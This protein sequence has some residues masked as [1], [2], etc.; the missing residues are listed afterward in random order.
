MFHLV[1]KPAVPRVKG[2]RRGQSTGRMDIK[3]WSRIGASGAV[4][5]GGS[6]GLARWLGSVPTVELETRLTDFEAE[7]LAGSME[8]KASSEGVDIEG[9]FVEFQPAPRT[10]SGA[11]T[12]L[13]VCS[14]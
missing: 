10:D 3:L 11:W 1:N 12:R 8:P 7:A 9:T 4:I 6:I 14:L 13:G 2:G 5:L